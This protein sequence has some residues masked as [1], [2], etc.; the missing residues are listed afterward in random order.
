[1]NSNDTSQ[2]YTF[3][4]DL[5]DEMI[6]FGDGRF[7]RR[8]TTTNEEVILLTKEE[9]CSVRGIVVDCLDYFYHHGFKTS[10]IIR[11]E[12]RPQEKEPMIFGFKEKLGPEKASIAENLIELFVSQYHHWQ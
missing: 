5:T 12:V 1:M 3:N 6:L 7:V 9:V 11:F 2:I 8:N 4:H 10:S